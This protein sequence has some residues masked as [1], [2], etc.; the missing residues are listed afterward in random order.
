MSSGIVDV[1]TKTGDP[2]KRGDMAE[3]VNTVGLGI[4]YTYSSSES[5]EQIVFQKKKD[6]QAH[7]HTDTIRDLTVKSNADPVGDTVTKN[8]NITENSIDH[9]AHGDSNKEVE[10]FDDGYILGTFHKEERGQGHSTSMNELLSLVLT[11]DKPT[12]DKIEEVK[13]DSQ[14][15]S[16]D[17]PRFWNTA[18]AFALYLCLVSYIKKDM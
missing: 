13:D 4:T 6:T 16:I 5:Q 9:Q 10:V 18:L 17:L 8:S 2:V 3:T 14:L 11:A 15:Q 12:N 1:T 7:G